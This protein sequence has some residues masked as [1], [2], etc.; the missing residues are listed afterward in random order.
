VIASALVISMSVWFGLSGLR[1][2]RGLSG[3]DSALV[4]L[5]F[6]ELWSEACRSRQWKEIVIP[7]ACLTAFVSKVLFELATGD[8]IF[9]KSLESGMVGVPLAH[10]AGAAVGFL[11]GLG[12]NLDGWTTQEAEIAAGAA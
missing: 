1:V 4:V 10:V 9:V 2:Y 11:V 12:A 7:A 6:M 3:I 5:L 8:T